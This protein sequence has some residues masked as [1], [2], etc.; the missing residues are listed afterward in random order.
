MDDKRTLK[1]QYNKV[2]ERYSKAEA[3]MDNDSIPSVDRERWAPEFIKI[4]D[5]LNNVL[6][7][8]GEH[9]SEEAIHGF[10]IGEI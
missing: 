8:I 2:L 6:N 1:L 4:I 10:K 7:R 9:T 3:Y 5:Q